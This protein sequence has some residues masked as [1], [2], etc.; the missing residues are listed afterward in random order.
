MG[1][2]RVDPYADESTAGGL[3]RPMQ[4]LVRTGSELLQIDL[5]NGN[6]W[7]LTRLFLV[8]A[9]TQ[10]YTEVEA[11]VFVQSATEPH[12]VG[13]ASPRDVRKR[14]AR[15]FST[16]NYE[17]AYR[18]ARDG[19][20]RGTGTA[21][22]IDEIINRWPD[23]VD[24]SGSKSAAVRVGSSA[25]ELWLQ[26][27]LDIRSVPNGALTPYQRFRIVS[28][29]RR[30]VALTSGDHRDQVVDRDE[31][32]TAAQM[33]RRFGTATAGGSARGINEDRSS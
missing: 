8:A 32:V 23:A 12:F 5:R 11:L 14:L 10:D 9:L 1:Q 2:G 30:Y 7:W 6:Y 26:D 18:R 3:S 31:V 28:E 13:I 19:A 25:L 22:L 20:S 15:T 27:D 17:S 16:D 24:E 21:A 4:D 33:Q 29:P